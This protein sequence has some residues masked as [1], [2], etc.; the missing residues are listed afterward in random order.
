MAGIF[1]NLAEEARLAALNVAD[2][3]TD[4]VD[5]TVRLGVTGLSRAGKTVFIT[6]MVHSLTCGGR[7]PLFSAFADG[8]I[9]R[10][11]LRPQP[12]DTVPRFDFETHRAALLGPRHHWPE[13]TRAIGEMRVTLEFESSSI[14]ARTFRGGRLNLDIVDYPGEWLLDLTLLDLSYTQWSAKAIAQSREKSRHG[15]ADAFHAHLQTADANGLED[16]AFT[17]QAASLFTDYLRACRDDRYALSALPPGRFL[18]PGELEGSPA[19]TFAPLDVTPDQHAPRGSLHAMMARR[20][21][22][23]KSAIVRPFFRDHFARLDRQIVLVDV[24]QA[25]NAGPGALNDLETALSDILSAFRPGANSILSRIVGRRIERILFA[26]TKAD[27]LHQRNHTRLEA[28]MRLMTNRAIRRA[29]D[30]GATVDAVAL[31]SLRATREG[32]ITR[33][34]QSMDCIIGTPQ[35]GQSIGDELFD[36]NTEAALFPGDL[37]EDPREVL[38][39]PEHAFSAPKGIS[40]DDSAD[41]RFLKFRPP[42]LATSAKDAE[43]ALMPHIRLDRTLEFL[44][45]DRLA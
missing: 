38:A 30:T 16:E 2:Y 12:D 17:R 21:E 34:G 43:S 45:G 44:L 5:P 20:Y 24:L 4:L 13:S 25:L 32:R 31:A 3:A 14:L 27:H 18:L 9:A 8:R 26:A 36:G 10:A 35:K 22:A 23:Y 42:D 1:E 37:P 7:L 11:Q 19:L 28:L 29:T 39:D 33:G 15:L 41:F 40:A 6:A